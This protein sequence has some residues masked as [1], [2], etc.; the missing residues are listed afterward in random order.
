MC[1]TVMTKTRCKEIKQPVLGG[2]KP[3]AYVLVRLWN[4]YCLNM[5]EL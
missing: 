3:V 5:I 2:E 1:R 4:G